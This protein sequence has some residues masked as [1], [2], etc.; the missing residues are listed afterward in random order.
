MRTLTLVL[1]LAF[2]ALAPAQAYSVLTHEAVIDSAWDR[3]IKPLLLKRFPDATPEQ[4]RRAHGFAYG[5]AI[6]QDMGYYPHGSHEFSDLTHYIRSGDFIDNLVSQAKTLDE[7]AFALGSIAHYAGDEQGHTIAVN[8]AMPML[9]KKVRVNFGPVATY[10]DDPAD[11][12]KTE[13]SFDV[14]QIARGFYAPQ[15]YHDFIGFNVAVDVL[16]RAFAQTYCI[17]LSDVFKDTSLAIN[18]YRRDVSS[19]I[20]S[21]TRIAWAMKKNDIEKHSPG[22]VRRR[23]IYNISRASYQKEWGADYQRPTLMDRFVAFLLKLVP[24]IGPLRDLRFQTP[25]AQAENL[26][27]KSFDRTLD[28]YR[29]LLA[30][31]GTGHLHLRNLNFDTGKPARVGTYR[32][33][34]EAERKWSALA[35]Q[36][37][38]VSAL[39][40]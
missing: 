35:P 6:I 27:M 21:A 33:A 17:H 1:V 25:N 12:L 2:L 14:L 39:T 28:E 7:Y 3:S 38:P 18:S 24:P 34:D 13:F 16:D 40:D 32:L 15:A 11:H 30:E 5:G 8:L 36:G 26:F 9:Y 19:L 22:I 4:L 37:C 23:F 29:A 31:A 20:P 10:E